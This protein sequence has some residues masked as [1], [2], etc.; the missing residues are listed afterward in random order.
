MFPTPSSRRIRPQ[1]TDRPRSCIVKDYFDIFVT[2]ILK[3]V[4]VDFFFF[5]FFFVN[6]ES[7]S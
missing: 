5:F 4:A 6:F 2:G 7:S 1:T 3:L